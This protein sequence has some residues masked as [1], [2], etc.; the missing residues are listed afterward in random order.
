M[1]L[2]LKYVFLYLRWKGIIEILET[3]YL[4]VEVIEGTGKNNGDMGGERYF[5]VSVPGQGM[6]VQFTN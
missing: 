5:N 3:E 4:G 2:N 6:F 1:L